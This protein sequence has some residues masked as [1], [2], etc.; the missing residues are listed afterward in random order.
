MAMSSG[1][2]SPPRRVV[3]EAREYRV[4][5]VKRTED[6]TAPDRGGSGEKYRD[7]HYFRLLL[8]KGPTLEVYFER[9]PRDRKQRWW[10]RAI[11]TGLDR[12]AAAHEEPL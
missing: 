2:P 8:E 6:T 7:R 3:W 4:S 9:R 11:D 12:F 1:E 10:A 5:S